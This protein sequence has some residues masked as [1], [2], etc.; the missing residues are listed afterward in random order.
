MPIFKGGE[1]IANL[2]YANAQQKIA[3]AQ[4]EKT[5]QTAFKDVSDALVERANISEQL[6]AQEDLVNTA[7]KSYEVSLNSYKY[8]I[9]NYLNV[10]ISQKKFFDSQRALIDTKLSELIN[11]VSLYTSLG[12]NEKID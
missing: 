9:G 7:K 8:G 1:N 10:L 3:L 12:G 5:I 4:Y 6:N 2:D 11:R